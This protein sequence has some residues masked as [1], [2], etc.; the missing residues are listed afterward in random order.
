M[1]T[2]GVIYKNVGMSSWN[3]AKFDDLVKTCAVETTPEPANIKPF[4]CYE[5]DLDCGDTKCFPGEFCVRKGDVANGIKPGTCERCTSSKLA[6]TNQFPG[7]S[8]EYDFKGKL[9]ESYG[10]ALNKAQ[11]CEP[12]VKYKTNTGGLQTFG[13]PDAAYQQHGGVYMCS[14]PDECFKDRCTDT[15]DKFA[16]ATRL[17]N[18]ICPKKS[19]PFPIG[20]PS[21][22][23]EE[24]V[25]K[26]G[27]L[28]TLSLCHTPIVVIKVFMKIRTVN[29]QIRVQACSKRH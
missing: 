14:Q 24:I 3:P 1:Y 28:Y 20:L 15:E 12:F 16:E 13:N 18:L 23:S 27:G 21:A 25:T 9:Y 2:V 8:E 10:T 4:A 19:N 29:M 22:T 26:A 6:Q 5:A 17:N 7:A 11:R